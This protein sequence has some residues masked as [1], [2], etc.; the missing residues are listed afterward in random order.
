MK[1]EQWLGDLLGQN[2]VEVCNLLQ[3]PYALHFLNAWS[4]FESKCCGGYAEV[5]ALETFAKP[6]LLED[7]ASAVV[8]ESASHFPHQTSGSGTIPTAHVQSEL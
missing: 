2:E 1:F 8:A 5:A 3:D 6:L 4:L 7:Y